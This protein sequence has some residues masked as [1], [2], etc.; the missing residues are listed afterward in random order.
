MTRC[1]YCEAYQWFGENIC[2]HTEKERMQNTPDRVLL[3]L[4]VPLEPVEVDL[5]RPPEEQLSGIY[6]EEARKMIERGR[7]QD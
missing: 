4:P 3:D 5:T 7:I 1:Y 6:L 2:G